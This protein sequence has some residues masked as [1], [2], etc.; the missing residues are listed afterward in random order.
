MNDEPEIPLAEALLRAL[1]RIARQAG[2]AIHHINGDP[3]DNRL[4][5]IKA[6]P[7]GE[8]RKRR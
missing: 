7:V 5:N 1:R 4:E 8:N 2:F 3:T 6:V